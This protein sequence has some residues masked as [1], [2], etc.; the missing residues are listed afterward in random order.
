MKIL[1]PTDFSTTSRANAEYASSLAK[2]LNL[3]AEIVLM[4]VF[5]QPIVITDLMNTSSAA[6]KELWHISDSKMDEEVKYLKRKYEIKARGIV[7]TGSKITEIVDVSR[8]VKAALVIMNRGSTALGIIRKTTIPVLIV[9]KTGS[10]LPLRH[11]VFATDFHLISDPHS[12]DLLFSFVEKYK[13]MLQVLH[14]ERSNTDS[15]E[16]KLQLAKVLARVTYWYRQIESDNVVYGIKTFVETHP[17]ELLIL[18]SHRHNLFK[19]IFGTINT[20]AVTS[21]THLPLLILNDS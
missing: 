7:R 12:L 17:A 3:G 6:A 15:E 20:R 13:A 4:H 21:E 18:L 5:T 19:R 1:V 8:Q 14:V 11:I 9:D 16:G 2:V 10:V